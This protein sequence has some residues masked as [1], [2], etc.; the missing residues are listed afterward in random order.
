MTTSSTPVPNFFVIGAPKCGTTSLARYLAQHPDVY[1]S[2]VK[3][4]CFFAPEVLHFDPLRDPREGGVVLE[5]PKYLE[6]FAGVRR[7]RAIGE[8]SVAYLAS[9]AAAREIRRRLPD[10]R[11]IAVL[12]DPA[13][14]LFS[15][16]AAAR[17]SGAASP[18]FSDWMTREL[19]IEASRTPRGGPAW[20]GR[21]G[22]HLDRWLSAFP[23]SQ[24]RTY[25]Y[26]DYVADPHA[27][28]ADVFRFIGVDNAIR[29]DLSRRHNVTT[30][31]RWPRMARFARPVTQALRALAPEL[32]GR[33]RDWSRTPV[34]LAPTQEERAR[35]IALYAD[36]IARLARIIGRD[37]TAWLDAGRRA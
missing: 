28:L 13:D 16:Y 17:A 23:R 8:A 3:E 26:E 12:R 35:A 29:V 10:A 2:P 33:A 37:L 31:P 7:E 6:L 20:A 25:L 15:H 14:R 30:I 21:Y 4:P 9:P 32:A 1:M 11:L 5:W 22:L 24:V 27:L 19:E 34:A 36:D 18:G